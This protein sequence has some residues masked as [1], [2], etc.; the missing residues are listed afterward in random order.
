[1]GLL[2]ERRFGSIRLCL[3]NGRGD[4]MGFL[5][6]VGQGSSL[7]V[8]EL[9]VAVGWSGSTAGEDGM[10]VMDDDKIYFAKGF[11]SLDITRNESRAEEASEV[12]GKIVR[13]WKFQERFPSSFVPGVTTSRGDISVSSAFKALQI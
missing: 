3:K 11:K 5:M 13:R 4:L 10:E 12:K 1:M 8:V 2:V 7:K 9:A 6:K